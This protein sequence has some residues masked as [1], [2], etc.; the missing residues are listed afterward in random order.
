VSVPSDAEIL[1]TLWVEFSFVNSP[2]GSFDVLDSNEKLVQT[3][4]VSHRV[5]HE[6]STPRDAE[7]LP[8]S[9]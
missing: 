7:K 3:Q 4:V 5:L 2:D 6:H 8:A 1:R 9:S